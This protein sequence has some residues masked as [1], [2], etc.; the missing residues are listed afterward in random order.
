MQPIAEGPSRTAGLPSEQRQR[1]GPPFPY[2]AYFGGGGSFHMIIAGMSAHQYGYLDPNLKACT[3]TLLCLRL[4]LGMFVGGGASMGLN[5]G[6][7][8]SKGISYGVGG[9]IGWGP[10]VGGSI[11]LGENSA[12]VNT[13]VGNFGGG[14]G[15]SLGFDFCVTTN[16]ICNK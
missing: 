3:Y 15:F 11:S 9:D 14:G 12:G 2:G 5:L 1:S 13:G 16:L 6:S 7:P 4:G 10:A 8:P